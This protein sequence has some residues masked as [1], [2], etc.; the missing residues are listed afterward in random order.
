MSPELYER[1][2]QLPPENMI[3]LMMNAL[4]EMQAQNGRSRTRCIM[5]AIDAPQVEEGKWKI[6]SVEEIKQ[7]TEGFL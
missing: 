7:R 1:L 5:L 3:A 4:D 6:P 2:M